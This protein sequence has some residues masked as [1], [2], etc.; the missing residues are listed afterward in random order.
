MRVFANTL[1]SHRRN[2]RTQKIAPSGACVWLAIGD[3][4]WPSTNQ[5]AWFL[6]YFLRWITS[7][8]H[9]VTWKLH[10]FWPIRMEKLFHVYYFIG[11][12]CTAMR[13]GQINYFKLTFSV[14]S[15]RHS[16]LKMETT[17]AP[18]TNPTLLTEERKVT[19]RTKRKVLRK[20][21]LFNL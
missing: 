20:I 1:G 17:K 6:N 11:N 10:F 15:T 5:N 8:L 3:F 4:L 19:T 12:I 7:F 2:T 9:S 18:S 21:L 16:V 13:S 14:H